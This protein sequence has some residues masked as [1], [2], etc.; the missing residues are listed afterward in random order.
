M[1]FLALG[2]GQ[3]VLRGG[4]VQKAWPAF[5]GQIN[6]PI[7]RNEIIKFI[8]TPKVIQSN[9]AKVGRGL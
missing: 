1:D 6:L 8:I 3:A 4:E 5:E 7:W 2:T 9:I